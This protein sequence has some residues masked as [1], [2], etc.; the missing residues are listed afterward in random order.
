MFFF[1]GEVL[2]IRVQIFFVCPACEIVC[3]KTYMEPLIISYNLWCTQVTM[4]YRAPCI[5]QCQGPH[6]GKRQE[7]VINHCQVDVTSNN[8][9]QL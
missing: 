5:S 9:T 1:L 2:K 6:T 3:L 8:I 7:P 4:W